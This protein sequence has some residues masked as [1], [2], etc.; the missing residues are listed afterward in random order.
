MVKRQGLFQLKSF[1][2]DVLQ[3]I[4]YMSVIIVQRIISISFWIALFQKKMPVM[5]KCFST[6]IFIFQN[7]F[8]FGLLI[9]K[10]KMQ[11]VGLVMYYLLVSG[12]RNK[13]IENNGQAMFLDVLNQKK[14][15]LELKGNK[16][17]WY[18]QK[19]PPDI[20]SLHL[21]K[22]TYKTMFI[23]YFFTFFLLNCLKRR[24]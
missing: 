1:V 15:I 3:G 8:L 5:S 10:Q 16:I 21:S 23:H 4:E 24:R 22:G 7:L 2:I 18:H 17:V 19:E 14:Q 11:F 13:N 6:G 9:S 12:F 20:L